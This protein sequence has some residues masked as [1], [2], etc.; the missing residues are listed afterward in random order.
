MDYNGKDSKMDCIDCTA[1]RECNGGDGCLACEEY[2]YCD[3]CHMCMCPKV[4]DGPN[5]EE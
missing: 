2:E 5:E 1:G 3:D 4:E